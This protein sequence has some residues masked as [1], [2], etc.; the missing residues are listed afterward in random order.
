MKK[1]FTCEAFLNFKFI[2]DPQLS[3]DGSL[4]AFLVKKADIKENNYKNTLYLLNNE[5]GSVWQM[6][7]SRNITSYCWE[8]EKNI[9]FPTA[10]GCSTLNID[11]DTVSEKFPLSVKADRLLPAGGESYVL[12]ASF[13]VDAPSPEGLSEEEYNRQLD[14]Y[15]NR[16]F[17]HIREV[18]FTLNGAGFVN[19]KRKRI[20]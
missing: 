5:T 19:G 8:D 6:T 11:S 9:L 1:S 4:T 13:D 12:T 15:K 16:G 14:V 20:Y 3:P 18:P 10:S 7:S 2:N 17:E